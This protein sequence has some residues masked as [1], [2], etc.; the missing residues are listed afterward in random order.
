MSNIYLSYNQSGHTYELLE[1]GT[2]IKISRDKEIIH[3]QPKNPSYQSSTKQLLNLGLKNLNEIIGSFADYVT[4]CETLSPYKSIW[5]TEEEFSR[6]TEIYGNFKYIK[7]TGEEINLQCKVDTVQ[8]E[9]ANKATDR[10]IA[11]LEE[12][13]GISTIEEPGKTISREELRRVLDNN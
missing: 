8:G 12:F 4:F 1:L 2:L 13:L 3:V 5:L 10:R 6:R 9:M 7:D 11:E